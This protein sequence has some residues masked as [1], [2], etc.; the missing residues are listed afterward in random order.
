MV[1]RRSVLNVWRLKIETYREGGRACSGSAAEWPRRGR[2]LLREP[3]RERRARLAALCAEV[4][5]PEVVFSAGVVGAGRAWFE[6][7]VAQGHEGIMAKFLASPYQPGRRSVAWRKIKP[8]AVKSA[9]RSS[10]R[11]ARARP[12]R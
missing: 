8:P 11:T 4:P 3:L 9:V 5:L 7:A 6:A 10:G 1:R 2:C 12:N